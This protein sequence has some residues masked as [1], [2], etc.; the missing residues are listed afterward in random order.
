MC[1]STEDSVVPNFDFGISFDNDIDDESLLLSTSD[2]DQF[3]LGQKS[4]S[5]R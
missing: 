4:K 3:I 1:Q 2:I 5:T